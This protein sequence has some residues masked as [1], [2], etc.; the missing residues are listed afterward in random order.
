VNERYYLLPWEWNDY[1]NG[2]VRCRLGKLDWVECSIRKINNTW[3]YFD[4]EAV[5]RIEVSTLKEAII[6]KDKLLLKRGNTA[7]LV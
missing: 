7:L 5:K 6:Q 3:N 4:H 1:Y 2:Y